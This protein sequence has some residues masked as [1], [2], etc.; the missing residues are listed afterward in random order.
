M[1]RNGDGS[2]NGQAAK[3]KIFS[4]LAVA[5]LVLFSAVNCFAVSFGQSSPLRA[6]GG[7]ALVKS[8]IASGVLHQKLEKSVGRRSPQTLIGARDAGRINAKAHWPSHFLQTDPLGYHDSMN[9]Y[10]AFNMNGVNFVDPMGE[11]VREGN[12]TKNKAQLK[13]E[14][15]DTPEKLSK[16][17]P[18]VSISDVRTFMPNCVPGSTIDVSH[19]IRIFE[20]KVMDNVALFA[21][22]AA[23]NPIGLSF[24][25][26][27]QKVAN[28]GLLGEN[29]IISIFNNNAHYQSGCFYAAT[30]VFSR[31]MIATLKPGE[32]DDLSPL[33][34]ELSFKDKKS[35]PIEK[36]PVGTRI[37][38]YNKIDKYHGTLQSGGV[39]AEWVIKTGDDS[40]YGFG[41]GR[42]VF[43]IKSYSEWMKTMAGT[44]NEY[45]G[46]EYRL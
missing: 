36:L 6:I 28:P 31:A 25:T 10:Q 9:L 43:P 14:L 26:S 15:G 23:H 32:W 12:W 13:V 3:E 46:G 20:R 18:G 27:P 33:G 35:V 16:L 38:F 45:T 8:K 29:D 37:H 1:R 30:L 21:N 44:Y 34:Y 24:S 4:P 40:Y 39:E 19:L 11:F 2:L 22:K 5:L 41:Y 17:M 7:T 42:N